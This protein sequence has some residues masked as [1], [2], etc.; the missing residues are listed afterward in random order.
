MAD[1]SIWEW[2]INPLDNTTLLLVPYYLSFAEYTQIMEFRGINAAIFRHW[3]TNEN[4]NF[5]FANSREQLCGGKQS[6]QG[7]FISTARWRLF[8]FYTLTSYL[9]FR[10]N[11]FAF[12]KQCLSVGGTLGGG[13][14]PPLKSENIK[15][16]TA[17]LKGQIVRPKMF[18]SSWSPQHQLMPSYDVTITFC[19]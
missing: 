13:G 2:K 16:M 10:V 8:M 18:L 7:K 1:K 15:A 19:S 12:K 4:S 6:W 14:F 11:W 5:T 17:K 9:M 3:K